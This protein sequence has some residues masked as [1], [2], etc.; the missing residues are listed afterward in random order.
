MR[1]RRRPSQRAGRLAQEG[2]QG[3]GQV[4]AE[5]QHQ[6]CQDQRPADERESL[7]RRLAGFDRSPVGDVQDHLRH[8]DEDDREQGHH[9]DRE[10]DVSLPNGRGENR[11]LAHEQADFFYRRAARQIDQMIGKLEVRPENWEMTDLD[12]QSG[13]VS[14]GANGTHTGS[15]SAAAGTK[16]VFAGGT[17]DLNAGSSVTGAG[18]IEFT[19][20]TA[21]LAGSYDITGTTRV[22]GGIANFNGTATSAALDVTAGT[23][24]GSGV[25]TATGSTWWRPVTCSV[26]LMR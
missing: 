15:F 20:G 4:E 9:Q 14:I 13:M 6:R 22:N 19:G 26:T 18:T 12:V 2:T 23:L 24:G 3:R 16:I 17:N 10:P 11:E 1:S 5:H 8:P 7:P 21:N 25:L